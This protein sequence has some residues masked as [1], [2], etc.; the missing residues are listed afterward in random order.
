MSLCKR[1]TKAQV[2]YRV[3]VLLSKLQLAKNGR[4]SLASLAVYKRTVCLSMTE[5]ESRAKESLLPPLYF[6]LTNNWTKDLQSTNLLPCVAHWTWIVCVETP[7]LTLARSITTPSACGRVGGQFWP[8]LPSSL[9]F[10]LTPHPQYSWGPTDPQFWRLDKTAVKRWEA[11]N[12]YLCG[13][14]LFQCIGRIPAI[15]LRILETYAQ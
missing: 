5:C 6:F 4:D 7:S 13:A 12:C 1:Y 8:I 11:G 3:L 14:P 2:N 9:Q 10:P 15:I